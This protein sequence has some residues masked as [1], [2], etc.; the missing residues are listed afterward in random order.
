MQPPADDWNQDFERSL[1]EVEQSLQD[2]KDRYD[3][4]SRDQQQQSELQ[5]R[6]QQ[7]Q[8]ELQHIQQQIETLEVNL[9][10][11]LISWIRVQEPFWQMVRFGGLGLVLGWVLHWLL[12]KR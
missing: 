2:L 10:S 12:A 4:V 1:I 9:E 7:L 8:T 6:L 3:Q 5:Q 11:R